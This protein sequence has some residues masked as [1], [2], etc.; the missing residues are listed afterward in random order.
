[1][2]TLIFVSFLIGFALIQNLQAGSD[3]VKELMKDSKKTEQVMN[4]IATNQEMRM[5]MMSK[6]ME[7]MHGKKDEMMKMCKMM[8]KDGEMHSTMMKMMEGMMHKDDSDS[9]EKDTHSNHKH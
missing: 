3:D 7:T 8:M 2:K 9:K 4:H 6:M 5:E 1:M